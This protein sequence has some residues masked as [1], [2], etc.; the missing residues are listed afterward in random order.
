MGSEG[1]VLKRFV[2]FLCFALLASLLAVADKDDKRHVPY[3]IP[4]PDALP[5]PVPPQAN[6][7]R[8]AEPQLVAVRRVATSAKT[9]RPGKCYGIDVS[10]YQGKINWTQVKRDKRVSYVYLKATEGAGLVD[11][12]YKQNLRGARKVGLPV[13]VYHF[14]SPSAPSH[15][16]LANFVK[17]VNPRTQD[18]IPIVD[19]EVAPRRKSQ[20]APF[21]KRLRA[22][23]DGVYK[24]FG[25]K[26][27]IYTSMNFYNEYLAGRFSD[28]PFMFARYSSVVP[29]TDSRIRFFVWQFTA[30]GRVNGIR[31]D[32][33]RSCLMNG[34]TIE[35]IRYRR[36]RK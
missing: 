4:V 24:H 27:M 14:F 9:N 6:I 33:D 31:G 2:C 22:F 34:Y 25:C 7:R 16:Q 30:S 21:L 17:T 23:V 26:P 13:G 29:K 5:R 18:L 20:V 12:T 19:V 32:V 36:Q 8:L 11:P 3:Y 1:R 35:D 15:Q 10:R 28:C